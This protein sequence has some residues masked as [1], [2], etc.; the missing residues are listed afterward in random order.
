MNIA[1]SEG[2]LPSQLLLIELHLHNLEGEPLV[3]Q[4]VDLG[5]PG[6]FVG[7]EPEPSIVRSKSVCSCWIILEIFVS[8]L[9]MYI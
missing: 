3:E 1:N 8:R 6:Q 7:V 2:D 5:A 9:T 4:A